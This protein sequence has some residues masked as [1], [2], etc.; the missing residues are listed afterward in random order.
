MTDEDKLSR[1]EN[2]IYALE[3]E[4][5]ALWRNA[6]PTDPQRQLDKSGNWSQYNMRVFR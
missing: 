3:E 6:K 1:L 4:N 2:R 5:K